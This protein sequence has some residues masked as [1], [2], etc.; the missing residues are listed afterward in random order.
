[1]LKQILKLTAAALAMVFIPGAIP[2]AIICGIKRYR[3]SRK[4][5]MAHA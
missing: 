1:M 4:A 5:K 2:I 3:D